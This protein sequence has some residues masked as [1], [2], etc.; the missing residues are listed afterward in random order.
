[1]GIHIELVLPLIRIPR[2]PEYPFPYPV[3]DSFDVLLWVCRFLS[4]QY[5]HANESSAKRMLL[6]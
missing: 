3:N 4:G 1:M 5:D 6:S 2:A